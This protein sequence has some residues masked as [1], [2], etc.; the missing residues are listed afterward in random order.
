MSD[1]TSIVNSVGEDIVHYINIFIRLVIGCVIIYLISER[2][3][4]YDEI[5]HS[6][7]F[8]L[9]LLLFIYLILVHI[10]FNWRDYYIGEEGLDI[11]NECAEDLI[12]NTGVDCPSIFNQLSEGITGEFR[13]KLDSLLES[14]FYWK[15]IVFTIIVLYLGIKVNVPVSFSVMFIYFAPF[16]AFAGFI[17]YLLFA[18]K[19]SP[20]N[21]VFG[22]QDADKMNP[23]TIHT[24][25]DDVTKQIIEIS[26]LQTPDSNIPLTGLT[27]R[28]FLMY[29]IL[30]LLVFFTVIIRF[31]TNTVIDSS[32]FIFPI[33]ISIIQGN[34]GYYITIVLVVM[35]FI[36]F[37]SSFINSLKKI[38][39]KDSTLTCPETYMPIDGLL[40]PRPTGLGTYTDSTSQCL[41]PEDINDTPICNDDE[42]LV[43]GEDIIESDNSVSNTLYPFKGC[44]VLR[45]SL[46][47]E[48]FKEV[49][50]K[51]LL[52]G[53]PNKNYKIAIE[54][55]GDTY[56]VSELSLIDI[57]PEC[58]TSINTWL[59]SQTG[60]ID[61][62]VAVD[63]ANITTECDDDDNDPQC[64]NNTPS[65]IGP[66]SY[67]RNTYIDLEQFVRGAN[68]FLFFCP[69]D[70][71]QIKSD[72]FVEYCNRIVQ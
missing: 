59:S 25:T 53:D 29:M 42:V 69:Q 32:K 70:T 34:I 30:L 28:Y 66:G 38:S 51:K 24:D 23:P 71:Q 41:L 52:E 72:R 18:T 19:Y 16:K 45:N 43:C 56:S 2:L 54:K 47:P 33:P 46:Q 44:H 14:H 67:A 10:Q 9:L 4:G 61:R 63:V 62:T 40:R 50:I 39:K 12:Q 60:L 68:E 31:T 64:I 8:N 17:Y 7:Y 1:V 11:G 26:N 6:M 49:E 58:K 48:L 55:N 57:S 36:N 21:F 35:L 22:K 3:P 20:I 65:S 13:R 15:A 27:D 37:S 5:G